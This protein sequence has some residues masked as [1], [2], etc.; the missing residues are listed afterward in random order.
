VSGGFFS[1]VGRVA[2][3]L[4]DPRS[5]GLP[6]LALIAAIAYVISPIDLVPEAV[7]PVVGWLDDILIGL[8]ALRWLLKQDGAARPGAGPKAVTSGDPPPRA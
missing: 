8:A 7:L 1:R 4:A 2:R 6:K 5:P 3:L